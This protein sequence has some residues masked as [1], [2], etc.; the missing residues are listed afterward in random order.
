VCLLRDGLLLTA[1]GGVGEGGGGREGG[2]G[3]KGGRG[4][5]EGRRTGV[6]PISTRC[7]DVDGGNVAAAG[8]RGDEGPTWTVSAC[9]TAVLGCKEHFVGSLHIDAAFG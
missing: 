2:G 6:T 4:N 3:G 7:L 9:M 8:R 1:C 5:V